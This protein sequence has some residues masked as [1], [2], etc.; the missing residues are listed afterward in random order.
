MYDQTNIGVSLV[1]HA[2]MVVPGTFG[3]FQ[4]R[5]L[6]VQPIYHIFSEVIQRMPFLCGFVICL[7]DFMYTVYVHRF[8]AE[9]LR[10][11]VCF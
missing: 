6:F 8:M 11:S 1:K 2:G 5:L 4:C 9:T 7:Y 3:W 10:Q